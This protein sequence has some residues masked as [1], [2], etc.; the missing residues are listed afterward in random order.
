MRERP[1][2]TGWSER[3]CGDVF[4]IQLGKMLSKAATSGAGQAPYLANRHVQWDEVVL[5]DLDTMSFSASERE[6]FEL[7]PRDLLVCEGGEVGRTA[8]WRGERDDVFFQKAIH[9]L[10]TIDGSVLPE[11]MLR[12]MR[13]SADYGRFSDLASQTSIAHLTRE[14][15]ALLPVVFPPRG[16]QRRIATILD[17]LDD[18]IRKTE[19]VIAKLKQVKQGLLHDLLTRGIDENGELRDPERHP[20][21]FKDSPLGR[22]PKEWEVARLL[23]RVLLP[24]G[25]VDPTQEPYA[26]SVL[27]AP[28]HV[29]SRTGQL[30]TMVSA[31][32]QG[33]MSG[34]YT[35]RA[36]DVLYSKIRPYLRKAVLATFD[37]LCSA[38][39][40]P[41][42]P[43]EN[44]DGRFLLA[45]IL[46]DH[47][48]RFAEAVS[49]RSGF[50]KINRDELA[51]YRAALPPFSEQKRIASVLGEFDRREREEI[52]ELS[53]LTL[54]KRGIMDDLL[55]GRVRT[56]ELDDSHFW[57][58]IP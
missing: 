42:R 10:R 28:D 53:K 23:D 27:V 17:T 13:L 24:S 29:E 50:P 11:Y 6:K 31:S 18:L 7:R 21:Q 48:S 45:L 22:I 1:L 35:F 56:A 3:P 52:A 34:K 36:G 32:A 19:Q 47:F 38:D 44:T 39:M 14:K 57:D 41:L 37:G 33:A 49:M 16:E 12:Y 8:L 15:L 54:L 5:D 46:G 20:E 58:A 9:R 51:E 4:E 25:Q 55:T 26:S 40:Y 2:P 30:L 43:E